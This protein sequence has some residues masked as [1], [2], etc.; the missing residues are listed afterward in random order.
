MGSSTHY[1]FMSKFG[2]GFIIPLCV[3]WYISIL[4]YWLQKSY[5]NIDFDSIAEQACLHGSLLIF[6]AL[7]EQFMSIKSTKND[8]LLSTTS[9]FQLHE[10]CILKV[11]DSVYRLATTFS[12]VG[13]NSLTIAYVDSRRRCT[14]FMICTRIWSTITIISKKNKLV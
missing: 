6:Q 5:N 1:S 7:R 8:F 4:K 10:R 14:M 13:I 11:C 12:F 2:I 3:S 9:N